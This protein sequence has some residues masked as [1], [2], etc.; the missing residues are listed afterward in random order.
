[1]AMEGKKI[2]V[3][4]DVDEKNRDVI[5]LRQGEAQLRDLNRRCVEMKNELSKLI[6]ARRSAAEQLEAEATAV[7]EGEEEPWESLPDIRELRHQVDVLARAMAK[8]QEILLSLRRRY[9]RA[10]CDGN[11]AAY[12]AIQK[13]MFLA[14]EQLAAAN[15]DE[16][17]FFDAL[18][19]AG[20]TSISLRG[21][22]IAAIGLA[23]D[24]HS[25][26]AFHKRELA[27][28]VPEALS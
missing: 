22:A 13:R 16:K 25:K 27:E 20:V 17:D 23:R 14:V 10:V 8:Q 15:Q 5:N 3:H 21:M 24:P 4:I 12:V 9:S 19:R 28:F 1:M 18:H 7:L 26:A 6:E 2:A 11:R